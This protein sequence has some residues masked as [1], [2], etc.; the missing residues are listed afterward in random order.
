LLFDETAFDNTL[1]SLNHDS[2]FPNSTVA[3]SASD[4]PASGGS[5]NTWPSPDTVDATGFDW[6]AHT[7]SN[8]SASPVSGAASSNS[9]LSVAANE[10][11]SGYRALA[12]RALPSK[13]PE[14]TNDAAA[15]KKLR[16]ERNSIAARKYRQK[17]ID[18]ITELEELL[19][20]SEKERLSLRVEVER[21]KT[22][23][24]VL[25][26]IASSSRK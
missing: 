20:K 5:G 11:S 18:R 15:H 21:W 6:N 1:D 26:E 7:T 8:Q 10:A 24:M 2:L 17:R 12:K 23:A 25:E 22:K 19:A 13:P 14:P 9:P 16:R 3:S 4:L